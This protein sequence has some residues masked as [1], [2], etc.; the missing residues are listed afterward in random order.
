MLNIYHLHAHIFHIFMNEKK[1]EFLYF[2]NENV[3]AKN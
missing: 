3:G 1:V 2:M